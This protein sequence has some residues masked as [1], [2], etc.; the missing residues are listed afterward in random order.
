[1]TK[2]FEPIIRRWPR[3]VDFAE[4]VGCTEGAARQWIIVDSIPAAWFLAVSR[5]AIGRGFLDITSESLAATAERKRLLR[6]AE[7]AQ[8][9]AAA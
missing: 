9:A 8:K 6:G 5:A 1:M 2:L 3:V 4:E 7:T